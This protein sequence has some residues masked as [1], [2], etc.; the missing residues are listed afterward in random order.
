MSN[1]KVMKREDSE[2]EIRKKPGRKRNE[3]KV[4]IAYKDI[5]LNDLNF[6]KSNI[7]CLDL[8][9]NSRPKKSKL[10]ATSNKN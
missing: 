6:K 1:K 4:M 9:M 3:D 5:I 7:D 8:L 10:S 2:L